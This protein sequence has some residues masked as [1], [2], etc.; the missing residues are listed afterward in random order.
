MARPLKEINWEIVIRR[1]E[2][3]CSAIEI[4]GDPAID[5]DRDT[6]YRRFKEEFKCSFADY[7]AK[8][9]S[10]GLGNLRSMLYAKALNNKAPGNAQILM[11]YARCELGMKESDIVPMDAP[12]QENI[13]KSHYIMQ[14][15]YKLS[16]LETNENKS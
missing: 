8:A 5:V 12:N 13:D 10:H 11:F 14:L 6:F 2:A 16:Q 15:E 3:G 9:H 1:M 4:Y 7:S